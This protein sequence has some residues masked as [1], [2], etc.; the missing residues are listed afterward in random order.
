MSTDHNPVGLLFSSSA[1]D[2]PVAAGSRPSLPSVERSPFLEPGAALLA[3]TT[4][5]D[6]RQDLLGRQGP[7]S[8]T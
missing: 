5:S 6:D 1:V 7:A 2:E 3:A 8:R 4:S